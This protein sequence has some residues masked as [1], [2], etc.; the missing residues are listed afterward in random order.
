MLLSHYEGVSSYLFTPVEFYKNVPGAQSWSNKAS[1]GLI[2][3][4][5]LNMFAGFEFLILCLCNTKTAL[6]L[7]QK[8]AK[9]LVHCVF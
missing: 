1:S 9:I 6:V 3:K 7:K 5:H 4:I 2:F 8:L